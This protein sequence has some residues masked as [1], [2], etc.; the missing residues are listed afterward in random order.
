MPN[1]NNNTNTQ[2]PEAPQ[3]ETRFDRMRRASRLTV[4]A[5]SATE[6][7]P[8][9]AEAATPTRR[10]RY[11][12][13][14]PTTT[15]RGRRYSSSKYTTAVQASRMPGSFPT[16]ASRNPA[17]GSTSAFINT[18]LNHHEQPYYSGIQGPDTP[19]PLSVSVKNP[20]LSSTAG[21]SNANVNTTPRHPYYQGT[22]HHDTPRPLPTS[23][24]L[25]SIR[26]RREELLPEY[27]RSIVNVA[28]SSPS[29]G[30][31]PSVGRPP[32]AGCN[33]MARPLRLRYLAVIV[34]AWKLRSSAVSSTLTGRSTARKKLEKLGGTID[35]NGKVIWPP[36]RTLSPEVLGG[37]H[38]DGRKPE[39][40]HKKEP[41][42]LSSVVN[43]TSAGFLSLPTNR[44][45]P[46]TVRKT[47]PA[48]RP[49]TV[50]PESAGLSNLTADSR[51]PQPIHKTESN[52]LSITEVDP[53]F[54]PNPKLVAAVRKKIGAS[55]VDILKVTD[56]VSVPNC[57]PA[58]APVSKTAIS[59]DD[60]PQETSFL[61]EPFVLTTPPHKSPSTGGFDSVCLKTPGKDDDVF[62][63]ADDWVK[64]D[65]EEDA[66]VGEG[67]VEIM[68]MPHRLQQVHNGAERKWYKLGR[69]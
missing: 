26:T 46:E 55:A 7:D 29:V 64:L 32:S 18:V 52:G 49:F 63:E 53:K 43:S 22:A 58:S 66:N 41:T 27:G 38:A 2:N 48:V 25:K 14:V 3:T 31:S 51:K 30:P 36:V 23:P 21:A 20:T 59:T 45:K 28:P 1:N 19:R 10:D 65:D 62:E 12:Q 16:D 68:K 56:T 5:A 47:D 61:G 69:R 8:H 60:D 39:P 9:P 6:G 17:S 24:T 13:M 4:E 42:G 67:Q 15:M 54:V 33:F 34:H 50:N 35:P 37:I 57:N 44:G 40:V 11:P